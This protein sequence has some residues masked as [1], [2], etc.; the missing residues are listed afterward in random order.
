MIL[1]KYETHSIDLP[2]LVHNLRNM[3]LHHSVSKLRGM[4]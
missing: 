4:A 1:W 3:W 2:T